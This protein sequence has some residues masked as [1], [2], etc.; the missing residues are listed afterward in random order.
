MLYELHSLNLKLCS[1][2]YNKKFV[3]HLIVASQLCSG[4]QHNYSTKTRQAGQTNEQ[5]TYSHMSK[6]NPHFQ[7]VLN[8]S[9]LEFTLMQLLMLLP[10]PGAEVYFDFYIYLHHFY[11]YFF[12]KHLSIIKLTS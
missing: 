4:W 2:Q 11:F 5:S 7:I 6:F 9:S 12:T 8:L 1:I 3:L 10:S